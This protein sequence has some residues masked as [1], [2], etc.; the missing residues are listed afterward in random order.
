MIKNIPFVILLFFSFSSVKADQVEKF[1]S[2]VSYLIQGVSTKNSSSAINLGL[3]G[4]RFFG[5]NF[6]LGLDLHYSEH[7]N[8]RQVLGAGL[9]FDVE[10]VSGIFLKGFDISIGAVSTKEG[11][12]S[13]DSLYLRPEAFLGFSVGGGWRLAAMGGYQ[14]IASP[15]FLSGMSFGLRID[16]KIETIINTVND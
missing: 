15:N 7:G 11:S 10:G 5:N 6:C 16:Y 12:R 4:G 13:V 3:Q 2:K 14:Y 9:L 8:N 1:R